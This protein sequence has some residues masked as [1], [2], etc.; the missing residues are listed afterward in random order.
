MAFA[1]R[2]SG[3]GNK[4][5]YSPNQKTR[6]HLDAETNGLQL[7]LHLVKLLDVSP[8]TDQVLGHD[9]GGILARQ[10]GEFRI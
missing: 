2:K 1:V 7:S 6:T 9:L 8:S 10:K 3:H 4:F 5:C